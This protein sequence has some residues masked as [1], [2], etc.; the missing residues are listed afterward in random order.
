MASD[1]LNSSDK[2]KGAEPNGEPGAHDEFNLLPVAGG[3]TDIGFGGGYFAGLARVLSGYDPYL[4]NIESAGLVT[5][6]IRA[7]GR[8]LLPYQ[9][10]YLKVTVPRLFGAPLRLEIRSEYSWET[11]L[12][13]YGL[14]NA[15]PP[16]ATTGA[17]YN[18]YGRVHP[19]VV[20]DQQWRVVDH[21]SA[22]AGVGYSLSWLQID[23][24][25]KL[26]FDM[27]TGA[28]E[29]KRLLGSFDGHAVSTVNGAI[30]WDNRDNEVSSHSGSYDSLGLK[31]SP[32]GTTL[33]PN[34]YAEATGIVRAFVPV[35]GSHVTLAVRLVGDVLIGQA[36]F[37]ELA[38]FEDTYALGGQ[39]GVRGVPAQRYYGKVK[40]LGNVE[41]RSE[42]VPFHLLGKPML[43]GVVGF[44]DGGRVWADTSPHPELDG[45]GVGLKY[46]VGGGLRLQSG[47]SFVLRADVA[48]SPDASPVGGYFSAGQMF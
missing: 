18:E 10:A 25:S 8:L 27:R 29:V 39:N 14:G 30:Q 2:P 32:G 15:S 46:G 36:P 1:A 37:Y 3:T 28:P 9:D 21:V 22:R 12:G 38:R 20:I 23:P 44:C 26:A 16:S 33:F 48:W 13:Y 4:W 43:F 45:T 35:A 24:S 19:E 47:S 42:I 40:V 31:V 6:K 7:D 11:T 5:F 34:R 17:P 41:V